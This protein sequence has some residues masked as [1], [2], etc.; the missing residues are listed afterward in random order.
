[1]AVIEQRL[2]DGL[3][4][5]ADIDE[6]R[7][8]VGNQRRGGAADRILLLR[9][10]LAPL[11]ILHILGAGRED[12]A[13]MDAVEQLLLAEFVEVL[14]DRL[15]RDLEAGGELLDKHLALAAVISRIALWRGS[16]NIR[17][18]QSLIS[19]LR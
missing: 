7:S 19:S 1:M 3:R 15:R 4:R 6:E 18:G 14:A 2:P 10:D 8:A 11:L 9:G 16:R 5:G 13:T 12:R 17:F